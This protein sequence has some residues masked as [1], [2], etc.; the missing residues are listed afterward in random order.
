MEYETGEL[1]KAGAGRGWN[2][3]GII[4]KQLEFELSSCVPTIELPEYFGIVC[5]CVYLLFTV[6]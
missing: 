5:T 1:G 4:Q 6:L 3:G 2:G